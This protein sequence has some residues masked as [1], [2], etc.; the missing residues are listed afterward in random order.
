M[1]FMITELILEE[2]REEQLLR[3]VQEL[4][5]SLDKCRKAQFAAIGAL[6]KQID[7]IRYDHECWK[8]CVSRGIYG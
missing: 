5:L 1:A 3:E 2:T 4:R 6:R 8:E 7:Q